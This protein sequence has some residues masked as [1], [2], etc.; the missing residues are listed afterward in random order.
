MRRFVASIVLTS[1]LV[2]GCSDPVGGRLSPGTEA[3]VVSDRDGT[4]FVRIPKDRVVNDRDWAFLP[5]GI[6][7]RV[8]SDADPVPR[9]AEPPDRELT[10]LPLEG[11]VK[12][13]PVL[14]RRRNLIRP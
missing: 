2:V 8:V 14:I 1:C 3:M 4:A 5:V 9:G 11:E 10:V 7:V 13:G 6:K 12:D